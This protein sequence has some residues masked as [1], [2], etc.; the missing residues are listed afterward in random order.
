[1]STGSSS[2]SSRRVGWGGETYQADPQ[3]HIPIRQE[4]VHARALVGEGVGI[5]PRGLGFDLGGG[6]GRARVV[7][8]DA[9]GIEARGVRRRPEFIRLL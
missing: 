2:S 5:L 4:P 7:T 3:M 1:M 6:K 9:A 8:G